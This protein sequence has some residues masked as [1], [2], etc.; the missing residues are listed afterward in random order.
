MRLVAAQERFQAL[1]LEEQMAA[2]EKDS[3]TEK[4]NVPRDD[5][6]APAAGP[7]AAK[8]AVKALWD[9]RPSPFAA[10]AASMGWDTFNF[11]HKL[12]LETIDFPASHK[13]K[14]WELQVPP[15]SRSGNS[16]TDCAR[17]LHCMSD[18]HNVFTWHA[19]HRHEL[20]SRGDKYRTIP[21]S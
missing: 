10:V 20:I 12:W 15:L 18:C 13:D 1:P 8:E 11:V 5:G 21:R 16:A 4:E 17:L 9:G 6:V 14:D 3:D 19:I 7:A 2:L